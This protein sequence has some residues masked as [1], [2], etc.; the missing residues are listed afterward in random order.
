MHPRRLQEFDYIG[1]QA[2]FVTMCTDHRREA[3]RDAAVVARVAW[4]TFCVPLRR[5]A[6]KLLRTASCPTTCTLS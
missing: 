4:F 1:S 6:L 3:F 2:Y 5:T